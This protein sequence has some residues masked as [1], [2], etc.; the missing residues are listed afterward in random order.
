VFDALRQHE[1]FLGAT[2]VNRLNDKGN[3]LIVIGRTKYTIH[4]FSRTFGIAHLAAARRLQNMAKKLRV[5]VLDFFKWSEDDIKSCEGLGVTCVYVLAAIAPAHGQS[6]THWKKSGVCFE[7]LKH[8]ASKRAAGKTPRTA[9]DKRHEA[10]A[11]AGTH[12]LKTARHKT[13][14]KT[15]VA[16]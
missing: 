1:A 7:T 3:P 16:A 12:V 6:I 13:T 10:L 11:E 4:T 2:F 15:K 9:K 14:K 5:N 8:Q